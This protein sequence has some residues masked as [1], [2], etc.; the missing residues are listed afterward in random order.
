MGKQ[1]QLL[2]Q[3]T[4]VELRLQVGVEFDKIRGGGIYKNYEIVL[5][6]SKIFITKLRYKKK[7]LIRE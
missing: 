3:L 6:K 5:E 4:E 2:L 1:S 7:S